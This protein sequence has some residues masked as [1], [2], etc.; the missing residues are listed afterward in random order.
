MVGGIE[1]T[2]R[3]QRHT[4]DTAVFTNGNDNAV[5]SRHYAWEQ[6]K[7]MSQVLLQQA[8][9]ASSASSVECL[10]TSINSYY[11]LR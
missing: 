1:G 7:L 10:R 8:A 6:I 9:S 2:R 11:Y 5:V 3:S 4:E